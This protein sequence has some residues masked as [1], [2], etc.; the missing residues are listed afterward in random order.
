MKKRIHHDVFV[1]LIL[2]AVAAFG[3]FRTLQMPKGADQFPQILFGLFAIFS[4]FIFIK[5]IKESVIMTKEGRADTITLKGLRLPFAALAIATVYTIL[6]K[7][8]GFF[9]ATVIYIPAFMYF[10]RYRKIP[11]MIVSIIGTILFVYLVF[12]KQLNVP[13]PRGILF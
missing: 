2:A 13:F 5:G 6:A 4:V 8:L 3:Y 1:G 7:Y 9:V 12:V 10:Y 11:I